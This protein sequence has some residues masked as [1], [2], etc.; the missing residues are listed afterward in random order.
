MTWESLVPA[1][2]TYF[3]AAARQGSFHGAARV[4]S[5][6]QPT[7]S[8][9]I[10]ALETDLGVLLFDRVK[11]RVYLTAAG[12][13]LKRACDDL[14]S[15]AA[16]FRSDLAKLSGG[17]PRGNVRL[18]ALRTMGL[19]VIPDLVAAIAND[20]PDIT[21]AV[22]FASPVDIVELL[23]SGSA[24]LGVVPAPGAPDLIAAPLGR[25]HALFVT[26]P[27]SD[28]PE[29]VDDAALAGMPLILASRTNSWWLEHLAPFFATRGI[30]PRIW[31]EVDQGEATIALLGKG[32]GSS[33]L[34]GHLVVD[35]ITAGRLA[36]VP[37]TGG[38]FYQDLLLVR[39]AGRTVS[40]AI[41][42]VAKLAQA[43]FS[44]RLSSE[45]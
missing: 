16:D 11:H 40:P 44:A 22:T 4:C 9:A 43:I 45:L 23:R 42:I 32:L 25:D 13:L 38:L 31:M 8:K 29:Q 35:A 2:L 30:N 34:P 10:Q 36:A 12:E 24:D 26:A 14:L 3:H 37:V 5:V 20:F 33:I 21:L 17:L 19:G 1:A 39:L 7:I 27:G 28:L 15:R 18:A 6:S 41:A